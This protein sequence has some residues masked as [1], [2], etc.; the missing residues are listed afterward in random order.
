MR[1]RWLAAVLV[2]VFALAGACSAGRA[3]GQFAGIAKELGLT[4]DQVT[5]IQ[6]I[7]KKFHEDAKAIFQSDI[8][9]DRKMAKV[10]AP[11]KKAGNAIMA[12]LDSQQQEKAKQM[13]LIG[14]LLG[15]RREGQALRWALGQLGL[16]AGQKAKIKDIMKDAEEKG[17]ATKEHTTLT[18]QQKRAKFAE[19]QKSTMDAVN[20][21]LTPAQKEKLKQLLANRGG[22]K[23]GGARTAGARAH[24]K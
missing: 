20:V 18:P 4:K 3:P 5:K 12:L 7:V 23:Q 22:P 6:A 17:K 24:R 1:T 16:D 19:L 10:Q 15:P 14:K 9:K 21:V 11:K 13:N 8:A 2:L